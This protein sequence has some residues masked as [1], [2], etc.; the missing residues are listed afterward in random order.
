VAGAETFAYILLFRQGQKTSGGGN[1]PVLYDHCAVMKGAVEFKNR[2]Y[3]A[4]GNFSVHPGS[5]INDISDIYPPGKNHQHSPLLLGKNLRRGHYRFKLAN[6]RLGIGTEKFPLPQP[7]D[8]LAQFRLKNNGNGDKKPGADNSKNP[9]QGGKFEKEGN[10]VDQGKK[11]GALD[12]LHRL[13]FYQKLVGL[14]Q[15]KGENGHIKDRPEE[16]I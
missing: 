10:T 3:Q 6:V 13:G 7:Y 9:L 12:K 4:R 11:S 5:G 16:V 1:L 8:N 14:V 2:Y 15:K